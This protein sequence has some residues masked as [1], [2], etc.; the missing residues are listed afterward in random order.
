MTRWVRI[1]S[2]AG[3][4]C[5][6]QMDMRE[7]MIEGTRRYTVRELSPGVV[8]IDLERGEDVVLLRNSR[9]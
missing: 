4:P 1:R 2:L 8:D 5:R 6:L 9:Q 7:P 3:E